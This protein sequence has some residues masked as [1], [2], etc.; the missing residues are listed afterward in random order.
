MEIIRDNRSWFRYKLGYDRKEK[1]IS[2]TTSKYVCTRLFNYLKKDNRIP[3]YREMF[4]NYTPLMLYK[5]KWGIN[6]NFSVE[7]PADDIVFST[8][9]PRILDTDDDH[10]EAKALIAS[11]SLILMGISF[12]GKD[13]K[14]DSLEQMVLIDEINISEKFGTPISAFLSRRAIRKIRVASDNDRFEISNQISYAMSES[15]QYM[16]PSETAENCCNAIIQN[17]QM[18]HLNVPGDR[19]GLDPTLSSDPRNG[20]Y[21]CP[22]NI[23]TA[24]KTLTLFV[25]LAELDR[26]TQNLFD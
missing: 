1:I 20:Y 16:C 26:I 25:G 15:Y 19:S 8:K 10:K 12:A 22:H 23:E 14:M 21:M 6:G 17:D 9:L 11:L 24:L 5:N 7:S 3:V 4:G 18:I 2:I 13:L